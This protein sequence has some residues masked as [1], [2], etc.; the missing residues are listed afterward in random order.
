MRDADLVGGT[1][2]RQA[3]EVGDLRGPL[4]PNRAVIRSGCPWCLCV[5]ALC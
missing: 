2:P 3:L 1:S 5:S 4:Q